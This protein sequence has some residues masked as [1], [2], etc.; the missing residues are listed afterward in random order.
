M[1]NLF[2][3]VTFAASLFGGRGAFGQSLQDELQTDYP[4][5]ATQ[6]ETLFQGNPRFIEPTPLNSNTATPYAVRFGLSHSIGEG[7]GNPASFTSFESF[8]PLSD[9]GGDGIVFLNPIVHL[10]NFGNPAVNIGLGARQLLDTGTPTVI[11]FS[12]WY[13]YRRSHVSESDYSQLS[14]SLEYLTDWIEI[15]SNIYI[16]DIDEDR[17]S[18]PNRFAGNSLLLR[19]AE[20]A[21]SGADVEVGTVLPAIGSLQGRIA[22]GYYH[23]DDPDVAAVTGWRVRS[24]LAAHENLATEVI[25]SDDDVFGT[26]VVVRLSL[27]SIQDILN[28]PGGME[29]PPIHSFRR[30]DN[31]HL[32]T[33]VADR[34]GERVRRNH[35]IVTGIDD[36][37][38][39]VNPATNLPYVF[40]FANAGV[41]GNGTFENPYG[42]LSD[43]MADSR[44]SQ[45]ITYTPF[46]G[47]YSE[48]VVMTDGSTLLSNAVS[49]AFDTQFGSVSL[50]FSGVG[51]LSPLA[52]SIM[53][54]VTIAS[55]SELDGFG[56]TTGVLGTAVSNAV[57]ERNVIGNSGGDGILLTGLANIP[58]SEILISSNTILAGVNDGISLS[59][60]TI[61]S[62]VQGNLIEN[63]AVNGIR[64][65]GGNVTAAISGN[66]ANQTTMNGL[67]VEAATFTGTATGNT[68]ETGTGRGISFD[69]TSE[70]HGAVDNNM[71]RNNG[72]EGIFLRSPVI[73]N[74]D[75]S[76]NATI[77]GN[78]GSGSSIGIGL[79]SDDPLIDIS[80][81]TADNAG[82]VGFIALTNTF[83]GAVSG[84]QFNSS[85]ILGI[86]LVTTS[87]FAGSVSNN[88]TNNSGNA[89]IRVDA[90]TV[91]GTISNNTANMNAADG[92]LVIA[93]QTGIVTG[94]SGAVENNTANS[95]GFNGLSLFGATSIFE[96]A[97]RSNTA[98]SNTLSGIRFEGA[99]FQSNAESN[100]GSSNG[101]HGFEVLA[102][103]FNGG[104]LQNTTDGNTFQGVKMT[105]NGS[106]PS[107]V[108]VIGNAVSANNIDAMS[109]VTA[110]QFLLENTGTGNA[111]IVLDGNTSTDIVVAPA[112]N[113]DLRGSI[114]PTIV[115]PSSAT[116]TVGLD[117]VL[118][119]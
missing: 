56:I 68:F 23:F 103:S 97:L 105:L 4:E 116:G 59:G 17:R 76:S 60:A 50:P 48:N 8:V 40:L 85:G 91:D 94:F 54:G 19:R 21:M 33:S 31:S 45:A 119:P 37:E 43:A 28:P 109:M 55:N 65:A 16:P 61:A 6:I 106:G 96:S 115:P 7:V 57:I 58:G 26:T 15:R 9:T 66:T 70:F 111:V 80:N 113:F 71:V 110:S 30:G 44:S 20:V 24:E 38:A 41:A 52:A 89:G 78:D 114:T 42:R 93:R 83:P 99:G 117:G 3:T 81:N 13:D 32:T 11:G 75:G 64:F 39:A 34:L 107:V 84:N 112:F 22:A 92:I 100:V 12:T 2:V 69:L 47:A 5:Y 73:T 1:R 49:H 104:L 14:F 62:S 63:G 25:V 98:M 72:T 108:D 79:V 101:L 35:F 10:D 88:T 36:G 77:S 27:Q 86:D 18:L 87:A 102:Q 67:L 53:G 90:L 95:N 29:Y 74:T 46:G 51:Q 118:V 82:S